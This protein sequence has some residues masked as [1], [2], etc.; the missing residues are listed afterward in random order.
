MA[1]LGA[2]TLAVYNR[3][4]VP[5]QYGTTAW[6]KDRRQCSEDPFWAQQSQCYDDSAVKVSWLAYCYHPAHYVLD[7]SASEPCRWL[8]AGMQG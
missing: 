7:T 1:T 8:Y 3:P 6:F 4:G 2:Q 5:S